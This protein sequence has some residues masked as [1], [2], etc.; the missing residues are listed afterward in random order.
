MTKIGSMNRKK[1]FVFDFDGT[2]A[3]SNGLEKVTM[4]ETIHRYFDPSFRPDDIFSYFG[5]TEE[6]ILRRIIPTERQE[7]ALDF[8]FGY[9]AERQKDLLKT[10]SG[11]EEALVLLKQNGKMLFLLTGR[12]EKTLEISL[13]KLGIAGFFQGF[14]TG[15]IEG[16]NKP[17]NIERL[18][19]EHHLEK[20]DVVYIGD[21]QDDVRS[22]QKAGIDLISAGYSH[23]PEYRGELEKG[24]P[25]NVVASVEELRRRL[26]RLL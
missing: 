22:M 12:S 8:F 14:Y 2:L 9:Y 6:G 7:E 11:I 10:F 21:S 25:G 24:N 23:T 17:Q 19:R 15:S 5:P 16:I 3:D 4:V 13:K 1:A 20:R 26:E 18:V